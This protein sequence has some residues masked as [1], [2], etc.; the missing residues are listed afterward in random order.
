M[1]K[2]SDENQCK[3]TT[4]FQIIYPKLGSTMLSSEC[5]KTVQLSVIPRSKT[6]GHIN[7]HTYSIKGYFVL[8]E[9]YFTL[10]CDAIYVSSFLHYLLYANIFVCLCLH[11]LTDQRVRAALPFMPVEWLVNIEY[12]E[13]VFIRR[14][15]WIFYLTPGDW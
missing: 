6:M 8:W 12:I 13:G 11:D 2:Y 15:M 10:N 5:E 4:G 7:M 14:F 1:Y 3:Y 9:L